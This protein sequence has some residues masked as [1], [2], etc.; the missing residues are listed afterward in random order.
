[1]ARRVWPSRALADAPLLA[2]PVDDFA[3]GGSKWPAPSRR[4]ENAYP[5]DRYL[6]M[7]AWPL[8]STATHSI[9][10]GQ[11]TSCSSM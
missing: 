8:A 9:G 5:L 6:A 3:H 4:C 2:A 1:M 7:N 10:D 11:V